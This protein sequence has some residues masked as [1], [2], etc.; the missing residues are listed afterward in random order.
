MSFT[1][2]TWSWFHEAT[3]K[4]HRRHPQYTWQGWLPVEI[5]KTC[6]DSLFLTPTPASVTFTKHESY[7][8]LGGCHHLQRNYYLLR[9]FS[10]SFQD[11]MQRCQ[12]PLVCGHQHIICVLQMSFSHLPSLMLQRCWC[13][14]V[15]VSETLLWKNLSKLTTSRDLNPYSFSILHDGSYVSSRNQYSLQKLIRKVTFKGYRFNCASLRKIN[16]DL[17]STCKSQTYHYTLIWLREVKNY[18]SEDQHQSKLLQDRG[19]IKT[20]NRDTWNF[21]LHGVTHFAKPIWPL[22]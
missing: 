13:A 19:P 20:N 12:N 16:T 7:L 2:C 6:F 21:L 3:R 17:I 1:L 9:V 14:T 22:L 4:Q 15:T 8:A 5:N 18:K 11:S 10:L